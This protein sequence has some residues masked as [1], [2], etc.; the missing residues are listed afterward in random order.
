M[1]E[2]R[3]R[4]NAHDASS[5]GLERR[6]RSFSIKAAGSRRLVD[7]QDSRRKTFSINAI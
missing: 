1:P 6:R 2:K 7:D 4:T 3:L 5:P